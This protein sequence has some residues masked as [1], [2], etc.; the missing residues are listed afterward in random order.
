MKINGETMVKNI[1]FDLDMTLFDFKK[2][3]YDAICKTAEHFGIVP[4]DEVAEKY[5]EINLI[6]WKRLER[7]E[8]TRGEVRI[9]RFKYFFEE[10]GLEVDAEQAAEFY[11][12]DLSTRFSY[13]PHAEEVLADLC[14]KYRIYLATNGFRHTQRGRIAASGIEKY[15]DGVFISQELGANKP[16]IE[17]FD[18]CFEM[19]PDFSKDETVMIGD[20]LTSD[21]K[22]GNIAGIRTI[23]FDPDGTEPVGAEPDYT[24]HDLREIE[25]ILEKI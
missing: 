13:M 10:L 8:I 20:S 5:S 15:I 16:S 12:N 7:G 19:I 1:L 9:N 21:I 2:C 18:K 11:E 24:V 23:W 25:P 3:E 4:T 22:G 14:G 17:F 6:Q